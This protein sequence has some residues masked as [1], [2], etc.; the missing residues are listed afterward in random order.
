MPNSETQKTTK[1]GKFLHLGS[2][3]GT[4]LGAHF[5]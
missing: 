5:M 4:Q 2:Q 3:L 1:K